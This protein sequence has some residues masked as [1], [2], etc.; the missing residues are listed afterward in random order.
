MCL[1][2]WIAFLWDEGRKLRGKK[3]VIVEKNWRID[4][5]KFWIWLKSLGE[6]K[7]QQVRVIIKKNA[8]NR[9]KVE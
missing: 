1:N 6:N 5:I 9:G 4:N 8:K 2:W 7:R 3:K